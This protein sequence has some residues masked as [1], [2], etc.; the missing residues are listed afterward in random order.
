MRKSGKYAE[1][2]AKEKMHKK[3][4]FFCAKGRTKIF[5]KKTEKK[6]GK[7]KHTAELLHCN[8]YVTR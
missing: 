8:F 7:R 2:Y 5:L 6:E 1:N 3:T 4:Y